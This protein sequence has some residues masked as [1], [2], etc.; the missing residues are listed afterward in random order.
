M[1]YFAKTAFLTAATFA[2]FSCDIL[3][4]LVPPEVP[5]NFAISQVSDDSIQL[6]WIDNSTNEN[7]FEIE[8]RS[9]PDLPWESLTT[10][11]TNERTYLNVNLSPDTKYY[12]RIRAANNA[13]YSTYATEVNVTTLAAGGPTIT[14]VLR[15]LSPTDGQVVTSPVSIAFSVSDWRREAGHDTHLHPFINSEKL[16]AVFDLDPLSYTFEPGIHVVS[17][18]LANPDHT[19]IGI[20]DT[21]EITVE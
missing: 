12:Y 14:P 21:V 8:R 9:D 18:K 19:F 5:T 15:I 10:A 7:G 1:K 17:L 11:S 4:T 6:S 3:G 13:G 16:G 20:E 2:F